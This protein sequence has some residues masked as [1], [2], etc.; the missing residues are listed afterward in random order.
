MVQAFKS[1]KQKANED[2]LHFYVAFL[3]GLVFLTFVAYWLREASNKNPCSKPAQGL[4]GPG[5]RACV[6]FFRKLERR[7]DWGWFGRPSFGFIAMVGIYIVVNVTLCSTNI[8]M[9]HLLNHWASR[10]GWMCAAN[11]TL[12]IFFGMK[13]TPL[14]PMVGVSHAQLNIL[15]R[16]VGYTAVL[17]LALHAIFYTIHFH[18]YGKLASLLKPEDLAGI[19]AAIGMIV[20]FLGILRHR[21]YELFYISHIAGFAAAVILTG[22]HR[23]NWAKRI[24][25]LMSFAF[26][27]WL[28]DRTIRASRMLYNLINNSVAFYPLPDG[29]TRLLLKKP[30]LQTASPGTHIFLWIPRVH[31]YENHPFTIVNNGPSGLELV[32]KSHQGFTKAVTSHPRSTAWASVDGPYGVCPNMD[33]YDKLIFIAG[34]S[35]AAF[36]FGLMNRILGQSERPKLQSV[37]FVWTVRRTDHLKWFSEHLSNLMKMGPAVRVSLFVTNEEATSSSIAPPYDIAHDVEI[38]RPLPVA[39]GDD[40]AS[41][42]RSET[43]EKGIADATTYPSDDAESIRDFPWTWKAT[44]LSTLIKNLDINNSQYGAISSATSLV[45]TVLPIL[46]G[47]G[48]DHYGVEWGSL[49]CSV[50]IFIGAVISAAGS[51]QDSFA[52]VVAGRVIMGFGSTV[53]E[54]CTSKILAHWFQHKGLGLVYGL[55]LSIGKL[56]VLIAKATAVPMRDA[57]SFWGWALWIPAIVC[58]A[59]LLQNIF[60]VWW[61]WIRPAWTRMPTGQQRAR[62]ITR[63]ERLQAGNTEVATTNTS[64]STRTLRALPDWSSLLRVPRFFWLVA[65]TQIL[66][67]GV[68]GGFNGL[69]ADIITETR[70]STAQLAGYT[71]AV[72]QVIPVICAPLIGSY[73]D[74]F[75]HRMVFVSVTSAIWIL[76]YCLIGYTQTNALGSMVIAS[77]ASTMNALPFLASIP[78]IV[79]DQLELGLVFGIWKVFNNAGS[80]IVDMIAGRLQDITPGG[81]YERVIAFFVAV[82]GLEFCLGL[83]Y[84]ILD[85]KYLSGILSINNKKRMGL[86]KEG[87]LEDCV[88]RQQNETQAL[89]PQQKN[90]L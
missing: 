77:V 83:F 26:G 84:G 73:F 64:K 6:D 72:Q 24:P 46:G 14:T 90:V 48:L 42:T 41:P 40:N 29:G 54:T 68:V 75:G 69:N 33:S 56:I 43:D 15:H 89:F 49:A 5:R 47:Y 85:R 80:V 7:V 35:G 16:I 2:T 18:R 31:I 25:A 53:I 39:N 12:C 57:T 62:E 50:A 58:F 74:F 81:T 79:P 71:S 11:M 76:V 23:P 87:K 52:L 78:L 51:N 63:R 70:G 32:M 27:L 8:V 4:K 22:L 13:N 67:A 28:L 55:D 17:L 45:N 19:G 66:Q 88:G 10:F 3:F 59:N 86:E 21:N 9:R 36:T 65:C 82:K 38:E 20:L 1:P 34:G 60:Y 30:G 44:A 61:V 37:E